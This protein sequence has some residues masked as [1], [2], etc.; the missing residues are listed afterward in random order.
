MPEVKSPPSKATIATDRNPEHANGLVIEHVSHAYRGVPALDRVN[1]AVAKGDVVALLGPSGCGKS[2]LLRAVAGLLKPDSGRIWLGGRDMTT[3][4]ARKRSIGMVFQNFALFPHLTVRENIAYGLVSRGRPRAEIEAQV[5]EMLRL[6]RLEPEANRFPRQLSGGQQQRVAVARAL[7]VNPSALLLDEPFGALDRALRSELQEEFVQTQTKV[8]ITAVV[9]T[10]DQE[11]AQMVAGLLVVMNSGRIEQIG[12]P[13][14]IY[15]NPA[16]LF[17]N[18]FMGRA[19]VFSGVCTGAQQVTLAN[20]EVVHRTEAIPFREGSQ[21]IVTARPEHVAILPPQ[22]SGL[23][24]TWVRAA[25]QAQHLL[26]D[27]ALIDGTPVKVLVDRHGGARHEPGMRVALQL[28][29]AAL[30]VFPAET[31]SSNPRKD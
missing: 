20:G 29:P 25:P 2:T 1:F 19:N 11:E 27:L 22:S 7:A 14:E 31:P 16:T 18:R 17:V 10:H 28:D 4:P 23:A 8:G 30:H 6:V 9:V 13:E 21:V 15:D 26:V 3:T 5:R 12:T 24:A